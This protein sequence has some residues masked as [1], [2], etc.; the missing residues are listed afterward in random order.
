MLLAGCFGYVHLQPNAFI[1]YACDSDR[2]LR[3]PRALVN[4]ARSLRLKVQHIVSHL[5]QIHDRE[6]HTT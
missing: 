4:L 2:A 1:V 6:P 5:F 3:V